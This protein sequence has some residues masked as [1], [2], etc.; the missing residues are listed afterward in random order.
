[1]ERLMCHHR[2][3]VADVFPL[4]LTEVHSELLS[5]CVSI[6]RAHA[7]APCVVKTLM[8]LFV[9]LPAAGS[10][11]QELQPDLSQRHREDVTEQLGRA[12]LTQVEQPD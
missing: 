9:L 10:L 3:I 5:V 2:Q 4:T 12:G 11:P 6:M 8:R 7:S 1:M